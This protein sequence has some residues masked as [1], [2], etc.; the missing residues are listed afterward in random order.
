MLLRRLLVPVDFSDRS[1]PALRLALDLAR[2][3]PD[4]SVTICHVVTPQTRFVHDD[5]ERLLA[6]VDASATHVELVATD[7]EPARRI[8]ELARGA[9][10]DAIVLGTRRRMGV[11]EYLPGS[12]ALHVMAAAPCP[13]LTITPDAAT[14]QARVEPDHSLVD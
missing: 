8:V 4:A 5:F 3:V 9:H 12:V 2:D 7:G 11:A 14:A 13:V 6:G 1:L 10:C